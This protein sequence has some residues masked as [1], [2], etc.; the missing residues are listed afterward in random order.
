MRFNHIVP[1]LFL[2]IIGGLTSAK[3]VTDS[4]VPYFKTQYGSDNEYTLEM[5]A[6]IDI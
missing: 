1:S 4:V 6:L 5:R 2:F 3:Q